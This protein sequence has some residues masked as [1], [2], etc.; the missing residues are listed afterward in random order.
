MRVV[1]QPSFRQRLQAAVGPYLEFTGVGVF[2]LILVLFMLINREDLG[3]RIVQLFGPRQ[4]NLTTRT[5]GEIGQRISRYLV[6]LTLV[7]SGYGLIVGLGLWAIGVP[8]A[9]LWGC[10]AAMMRFIPY[11]GAAIA[12]FL[13]ARLLG[14]PLPRLETA[15]GSA[16]TLRGGRGGFEL[17][18]AGHLRQDHR[19]VGPWT[20]RRGDVLDVALGAA[21]HPVVDAADTLPGS[22]GQVRHEPELLRDPPGRGSRA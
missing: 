15:A 12:F 3:D 20:P 5:M 2:V 19:R 11:V 17:S 22:P 8:Y 6:M 21:R 9:A 4:I 1:D 16:R 7:N 10:L 18:G 13:P 14:R